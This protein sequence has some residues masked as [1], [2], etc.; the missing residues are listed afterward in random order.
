MSTKEINLYQGV[1]ERTSKGG[2]LVLKNGQPLSPA[3]SQ[4]LHNHSPDGFNWGYGGSGPAQL[5]LA[6][7]LDVSGNSDTALA[8]YQ[9]FKWEKIAKLELDRPWDM[10][11]SEIEGW[12]QVA[13]GVVQYS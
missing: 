11:D 12:L 13:T 4:K 6:L 8:H 5:A 7:L 9:R 3:D 2:F 1:P 10:T